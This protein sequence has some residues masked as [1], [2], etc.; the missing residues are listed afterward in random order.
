MAAVQEIGSSSD[1]SPRDRC[2][3]HCN[4]SECGDRESSGSDSHPAPPRT[5]HANAGRSRQRRRDWLQRMDADTDY[6]NSEPDDQATQDEVVAFS[7]NPLLD[8]LRTL[9]MW[10]RLEDTEDSENDEV[11]ANG[12]DQRHHFYVSSTD[13]ESDMGDFDEE[14]LF[15]G[16]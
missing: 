3:F 11:A 9:M 13:E 12:A 16:W 10:R 2:A 5:S 6:T 15:S 14:I 7:D 8:R 4:M 1:S